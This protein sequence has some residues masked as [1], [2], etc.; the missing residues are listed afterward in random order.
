MMIRRTGVLA[1][2][3]LLVAGCSFFSRPKNTFYSLETLP[4]ASA[5]GTAPA[6]PAAAPAAGAP[7]GVP[8]GIDTLELPPGLDRRG[9]V[10][11]GADHK[12]EVRGTN[13]WT[14]DLQE[15]VLH[16]LAFDLADRLPEG[17]V[18]LPGQP[19]PNAMRSVS[20]V[21]GDLAPGPDKVFVL[22]ARWTMDTVTHHERITLPLQTLDS[23]AIVTAM[24]QAIATLADRIAAGAR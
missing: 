6:S 15:M 2:A 24:S 21:L 16:T 19:K 8:I 20:I 4:A 10:V 13:Q 3:T 1:V 14:S 23:P 17:R 12:V 7:R 11:R 5:T 9:I 18:V 22:D